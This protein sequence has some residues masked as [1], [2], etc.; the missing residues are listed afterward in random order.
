MYLLVTGEIF[1]CSSK[2]WHDRV[3]YPLGKGLT[4][5]GLSPKDLLVPTL[6]WER[7]EHPQAVR[8]L[9]LLKGCL[10]GSGCENKKTVQKISLNF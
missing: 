4:A 5:S 6:L 8:S 9:S 7:W 2:W 1:L 10:E 3:H